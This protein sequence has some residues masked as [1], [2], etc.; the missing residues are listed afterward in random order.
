MSDE[1]RAIGKNTAVNIGLVILF[2]V[3]T[4]GASRWA[5]STSHELR[6][7]RADLR[8]G[9]QALRTDIDSGI[10]EAQMQLWI[11]RLKNQNPDLMVPDIQ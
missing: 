6:Q 3:A 8:A 2:T 7:L 11:E 4:W 10:D 1:S 9:F 5:T